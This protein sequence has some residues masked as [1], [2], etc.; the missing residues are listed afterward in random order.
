MYIFYLK[1]ESY[2]TEL[3]KKNKKTFNDKKYKIY[4][5]LIYVLMLFMR[6]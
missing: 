2:E 6:N 1:T 4:S 3:Q 5:S